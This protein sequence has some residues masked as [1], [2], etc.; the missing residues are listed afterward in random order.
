MF[1]K[2]VHFQTICV[3]KVAGMCSACFG[4]LML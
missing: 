4:V 1:Y 3:R 2:T